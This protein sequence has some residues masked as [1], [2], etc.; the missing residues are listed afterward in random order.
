MASF[1]VGLV[2]VWIIGL[3]NW[4]MPSS[5]GISKPVPHFFLLGFKIA[6]VL[7]LWG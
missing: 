4:V 6:G 7:R 2:V 1:K 3:G 5:F